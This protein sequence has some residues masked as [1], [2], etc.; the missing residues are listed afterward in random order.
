[1]KCKWASE[2]IIAK[3]DKEPFGVKL[4]KQVARKLQSIP[5]YKQYVFFYSHRDYCGHGLWFN[6]GS[7]E[8]CFVHDGYPDNRIM[9]WDNEQDFIAFLSKQ[10]DYTCSGADTNEKTFHTTNKWQMN[11]QTLTRARLKAFVKNGK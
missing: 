6:E 2:D 10:S 11:N 4:T 3:L 8:L 7:F 1:M 5:S 9:K